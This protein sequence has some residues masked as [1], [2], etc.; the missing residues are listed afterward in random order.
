M[1][2]NNIDKLYQ[3][4]DAFEKSGKNKREIKKIRG[5][6]EKNKIP[7]AL[8]KIRKL[9]NAKEPGIGC[10]PNQLPNTT[11]VNKLGCLRVL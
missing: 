7:E 9:N 3:I 1:A 6:I 5:L 10:L 11:S 2:S 8:E 4:L